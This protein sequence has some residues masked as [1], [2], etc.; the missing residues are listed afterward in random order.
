LEP[1]ALGVT[2]AGAVYAGANR[3]TEAIWCPAARLDAGWD[4]VATLA[5]ARALLGPDAD[6]ERH[7][8]ADALAAYLEELGELRRAGAPPPLRPWCELDEVTRRGVLA[9]HGIT[10][11][12]TR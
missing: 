7:A 5:D 9:E 4:E 11:R 2:V 12:W 1:L 3:A 6:A 8:A 10:G